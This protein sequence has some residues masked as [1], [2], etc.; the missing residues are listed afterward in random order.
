MQ[1]IHTQSGSS[2]IIALLFLVV[3]TL[4]G[5]TSMRSSSMELIMA[6]N[7]QIQMES[8]DRAQS[9]I[10]GIIA[11]V[12]VNIFT[13][14]APGTAHCTANWPNP[15]DC[16]QMTLTLPAVSVFTNDPAAPAANAAQVIQLSDVQ[17]SKLSPPRGLGSSIT[18]FEAVAYAIIGNY[19]ESNL[20]NGRRQVVQGYISLIP[21]GQ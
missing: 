11:N 7:G 10:E 3:I 14:L 6:G 13:A 5:V 8:V 1:N 21:K 17:T 12:G 2:L 15:A 4:L 9:I 16:A 19:D 18:E 20:G